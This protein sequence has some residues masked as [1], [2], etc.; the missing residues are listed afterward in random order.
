MLVRSGRQKRGKQQEP[1]GRRLDL[2]A[3]MGPAES[4]DECLGKAMTR[5]KLELAS[6][7]SRLCF[8]SPF[9][10]LHIFRSSRRDKKE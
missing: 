3:R 5:A 6:Q 7:I 4:P 1:Q 8:C 2:F 9:S 10:K